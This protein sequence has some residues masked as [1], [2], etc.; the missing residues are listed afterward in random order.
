MSGH[1][2]SRGNCVSYVAWLGY[3][4]D[5]VQEA[6]ALFDGIF[7]ETKSLKARKLCRD[8]PVRFLCLEDAENHN[9][10]YGWWGNTNPEERRQARR[11]PVRQGLTSEAQEFVEEIFDRVL[12]PRQPS[13]ISIP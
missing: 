3:E 8:C 9:I 11:P 5:N 13:P 6:Y 4:F 10:E 2:K 1:W 7:F 12:G